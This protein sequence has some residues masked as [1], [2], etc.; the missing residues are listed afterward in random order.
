MTLTHPHGPA[1]PTPD[2]SVLPI[3]ELEGNRI[4]RPII[5]TADELTAHA[6][7]LSRLKD[8]VWLNI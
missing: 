6:A 3:F 5:P 1:Q 8:P 2:L 4:P 7:F